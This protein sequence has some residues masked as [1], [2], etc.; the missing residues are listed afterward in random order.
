M[1]AVDFPTTQADLRRDFLFRLREATSV[2]ATDAAADRYLNIA[3]YDMHIAP[4]NYVPWA[5][6]RAYLTTQG[7]YSTGTVT[8]DVSSSRTAVT[9]S[10]TAWNTVASESYGHN[11]VVANQSKIR[12][13]SEDEVYNVSA[14]GSDTA[15]TLADAYVKSSDLAAGSSYLAFTDEYSLASDFFRM[16]NAR[17]FSDEWDIPLIGQ[18]QFNRSYPRNAVVGKP[19]VATLI[20]LAFT[21]N[22]TPRHRILFHPPPDDVYLIPYQYITTFL[23][24]TNGGSEQLQM[25]GDT[26]EPIVP[27][28]YRL[29][30]VYGALYHWYRD[31]K[32]D[33]R[34][35]EAKV[36]YTELLQRIQ[37]EVNIG[38]DRPRFQPYSYFNRG[39]N[40]GRGTRRYNTGDEF[41]KL[42]I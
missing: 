20:Q 8:I 9:G 15:I 13:A 27:L 11:N 24:T 21:S 2:T 4:G 6:R 33:T 37:N 31:R 1:A 35:Q 5:I 22:T 17:S 25:D 10:S 42:L 38:Q 32:D 14:V 34:S 18:A 7:D 28:R 36:E 3:L 26:D 30:I 40:L 19:K 39:R 41:D 23:A 29:A 16:V 12:L